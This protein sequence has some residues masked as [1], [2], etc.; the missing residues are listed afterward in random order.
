MTVDF[1]RTEPTPATSWRLLVLTGSQSHTCLFALGDALLEFAA[2]GR[3]EVGPAELADRYAMGLLG[4]PGPAPQSAAD[5]PAAVADFLAVAARESAPSLAQGHPTEELRQAAVRSLTALVLPKFH[6]LRGGAPL[7]HRFYQLTGDPGEPGL[8]LT[9]E[10][11]AIAGGEQA[12]GLRAELDA[13]WSIVENS[14][15]PTVGRSLNEQGLAA[16]LAAL[17]LTDRSGRRTVTGIH[18][19]LTGFQYGRCQH[20]GD[21]LTPEDATA[22]DHVLPPVPGRHGA[23]LDGVWNL[24]PVHAA[25]A[26]ARAARMPTAAELQRLARRNEAVMESRQP[27]RST[28]RRELKRARLDG[29]HEDRWRTFL[30]QV[31]TATPR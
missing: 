22:V 1:Y 9:P 27:L 20:C 31:L 5:T 2:E 28:L 15:D 4:R 7:E 16:D 21:V 11:L 26:D 6:Q 29:E 14:F 12:A 8:R 10:L 23:D 24:A 18:A 19:A 30:L 25:C 3:T 13:R 17:T